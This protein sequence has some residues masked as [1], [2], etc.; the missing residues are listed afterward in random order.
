MTT[1][2]IIDDE[3]VIRGV[4]KMFLEQVGYEVIEASEGEEGLRLQREREADL[5]ISDLLMPKLD[6]FDLIRQVRQEYPKVRIIV[7]TGGGGEDFLL[8]ARQLGA[9]GTLEKP[10]TRDQLLKMVADLLS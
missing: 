8:K 10:F 9:D 6:G 4:I 5:V 2:L 1:I 7:I 3:P